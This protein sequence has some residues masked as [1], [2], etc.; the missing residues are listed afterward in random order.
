MGSLSVTTQTPMVGTVRWLAEYVWGPR[1]AGID[2]S[3]VPKANS[4]TNHPWYDANTGK[5]IMPSGTVLAKITA[6]GLYIPI[7]RLSVNGL[8]AIGQ[9]NVIV[10]D[11][12]YA[13]IGDVFTDGVTSFTVDTIDYTAETLVAVANLG[14][15]IADNAEIYDNTTYPGAGA[16]TAGTVKLL[17]EDA[18]Y[19]DST[20][21]NVAVLDRCKVNES[22]M[23]IS[24]VT[25]GMKTGLNRVDWL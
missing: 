8:A 4:T 20:D 23:P 17:L 5:W 21:F 11:A 7:K 3:A 22:A 15:N 10:D 14:A 18:E 16:G 1:D 25:A 24:V 19:T 9:K 12:D 6:S 13:T 2:V